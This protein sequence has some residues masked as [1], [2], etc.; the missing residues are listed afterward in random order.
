[1]HRYE[2]E[3]D[4]FIKKLEFFLHLDIYRVNQSPKSVHNPHLDCR[5][6]PVCIDQKLI[7]FPNEFLLYLYPKPGDLFL[8][9]CVHSR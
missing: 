8:I 3:A 2:K 4:G 7:Y 6:T 5:V 1:M 9:M